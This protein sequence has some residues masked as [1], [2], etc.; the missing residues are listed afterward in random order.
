MQLEFKYADLLDD[1][2][3]TLSHEIFDTI[4]RVS[5]LLKMD[6][7]TR[8]KILD[9]M[10]TERDLKNQFEYARKEGRIVG[11]AEGRAEGKIE[12]AVRMLQSCMDIQQIVELTG[13]SAA[14]VEELK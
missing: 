3:R 6:E 10:T 2:N 1:E 11:R 13:L 8:D 4:F 9:N 5:E 7:V 14:E 12:V